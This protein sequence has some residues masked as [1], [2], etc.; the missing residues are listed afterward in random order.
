MDV[1]ECATPGQVDCGNHADC[2][3]EVG[4]Y[5]CSCSPGYEA[6]P[7][8][9]DFKDFYE[10]TCEEVDEC[11]RF[12]NICGQSAQC[13]NTNGSYHCECKTGYIPS[14]GIGNWIQNKTMCQEPPTFN[15]STE[16]E[17]A[18]ESCR[19]RSL[20]EA[21]RSFS[22]L[23]NCTALGTSKDEGEVALAVM[24]LLQS[25]ELMVLA[26][27]L[28][29]PEAKMQSIATESMAFETRLIT[30]NCSHESEIFHLRAQGQ[31][32]EI[33][34]STVSKATTQ[35][36]GAA[37]FISYST[38][39]SIMNVGNQSPSENLEKL[40]LNSRVVSSV[41]GDGTHTG[42]LSRPVNFTL[43]HKRATA[44]DENAFCARWKFIAGK[45]VWSLG[46]CSVLHTNST[47]T[48]CSC[49]HL[50]TFALLM[51]TAPVEESYG[52]IVLTYVG[53]SISVL[54]LF[55]AIQT[56]LLCRSLWNVSTAIHLQL[57]LCLFLADLL[58]LTA[59]THTGNRTA[60]AV[61]A[62]FLHYLFLAAFT[63]MFLEGL[64]LILTVR[65]LKVVNYTSA[66]RFKK[67]YMYPFGYG[68]PALVVAVSAA[69]NPGGYGTGRNCWI[70]LDGGFQWIFM[71]PVCA[72]ILLNLTFFILTL[73]V[74]RSHLC[75]LNAD[76]STLK[77]HRLLTFKAIAQ[78][79][80][81]GC[82]WSLGLFQVGPVAKVMAYVFTII[83]SLQGVF[84]FLVHCILNHQVRKEY[85]QWIKELRTTAPESQASGF[86]MSTASPSTK[87]E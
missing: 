30:E 24:L 4:R 76:V 31:M 48:A 60:C 20:Q 47:H 13:T 80:I 5:Y 52:L 18:V 29:S 41:V 17:G 9:E 71:G 2:H 40:H 44:E 57:C 28:S 83:N 16:F 38:L 84:I 37:V 32:M 72:I 49:S 23:L 63:W 70:S 27:A 11:K 54:C 26:T 55:L 36:V 22:S 58:F 39:D 45:G 59:I 3:N 56:F 8:L 46:G 15:C 73:W 74:L 14:T 85:R 61:I 19:N 65:N 53:L 25:A 66:S 75:S 21:N 12:P 62:G 1:D 33:H 86:S 7:G 51:A 10:N 34:C 79:F 82:T 77:N 67:R 42:N 43:L 6:F 81:L 68:L 35:G 78:L 87:M 64:H 69:A 50:S